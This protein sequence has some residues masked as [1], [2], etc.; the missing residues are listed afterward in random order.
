M[1]LREWLRM[2]KSLSKLIIFAIVLTYII[3]PH[4]FRDLK[5]FFQSLKALFYWREGNAKSTRFAFVPRRANSQP[6]A[7]ARKDIQ[8]GDG[9]DQNSGMTIHNASHQRSK[10]HL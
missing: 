7:S 9:F 2:T 1:R 5:R 4:L 6:G 10:G 3:R 8:R